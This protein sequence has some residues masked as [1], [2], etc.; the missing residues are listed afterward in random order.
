MKK[1]SVTIG[2]D[3]GDQNH[4]V[5]VLDETGEE[6]ALESIP[7]TEYS[8]K[9]FF[10]RYQNPTVALE[11]GTHSPW[12]SRL[13]HRHSTPDGHVQGIHDQLCGHSITQ[14]PADN[15]T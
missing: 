4:I 13:L 10:S 15:P 12:I 7:N 2:M 5:V 14:G 11:A 9:K 1:D 3:L 8:L 6:I